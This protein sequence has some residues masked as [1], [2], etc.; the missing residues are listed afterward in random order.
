MN[1]GTKVLALALAA[2]LAMGPLL[3]PQAG[4]QS[5]PTTTLKTFKDGHI[6]EVMNF[7]KAG[8][9]STGVE[10]D[11]NSVVFNASMVASS[12]AW[13]P[14]GFDYP[15]DPY[16]DIGGDG[17]KDWA[18]SGLGYGRWGF[19]DVFN[20]NSSSQDFTFGANETRDFRFKIPKGAN[21]LGG[22]FT[23]SGLPDPSWGPQFTVSTTKNVVPHEGNSTQAVFN[24]KLYVAWESLDPTVTGGTNRDIIYRSFDGKKWGPIKELTM[25]GDYMEDENPFLI[26][27][28]NRLYC[29]WSAAQNEKF[30]SNDDLLMRYSADGTNWSTLFKVSP[31]I[32]GG[33]S[34]IPAAV[35][36]Q[37]QLYI[38]WRTTDPNIAHSTSS[39]DTD[40]VYRV[41]DGNSFISNDEITKGDNGATDWGFGIAVY[42]NRLYIFWEMA[43]GGWMN[44][45]SAY[46]IM[47][48]SYD[49]SSW[50]G[51]KELFSD[52]EELMDQAPKAYVWF[53][54]VKKMDM[55]YVIWGR[56]KV[57]N[58]MGTG[59]LD[60]WVKSYDGSKW[61]DKLKL[62]TN[63][64]MNL[65]QGLTTYNGRLYA[66]WIQEQQGVY[67]E[68]NGDRDVYW[69]YGE[70]FVR[71][72]DGTAWGNT[73][74]LTPGG[75][76]NLGMDPSMCVFGDKLYAAWAVK[77]HPNYYSEDWDI[78][79]RVL[80]FEDV[81]L[82]MDIGNDGVNDWS[83]ELTSQNIMIPINATPVMKA[84]MGGSITDAYKNR[85]TEVTIGLKARN[86]AKIA[87]HD[88]KLEYDYRVPFDFK[89]QLNKLLQ[90]TRA[91]SGG[92]GTNAT[93]GLPMVVGTGSEGVVVLENLTIEYLINHAPF[94]VKEIPIIDMNEDIDLPDALDLEDYF[95]DDLDD[96]HLHFS[97]P[98][99]D[100]P[101]HLMPILNGSKLGFVTP[102][103]DWN[104][105]WNVTVVA[106]DNFGL[107]S[108][109]VKIKVHVWPVNDPPLLDFIPNQ[110]LKVS[111]K[112]TYKCR[113]YDPDFGEKLTFHTNGKNPHIDADSGELT[114]NPSKRG[115][116]H[117]N[118]SVDDGQGLWDSQN[119][120]YT[121]MGES[122]SGGSS[123]CFSLIAFLVLALV[124][125]LVAWKFKHEATFSP[126]APERLKIGD[127]DEEEDTPGADAKAAG[128]A[129]GPRKAKRPK[130]SLVIPGMDVSYD[131]YTADKDEPV[132]EATVVEV[133]AAEAL[134]VKA[135]D[136]KAAVKEDDWDNV[137]DELRKRRDKRKAELKAKA[138]GKKAQ[139]DVK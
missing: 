68:D 45:N 11:Q 97:M 135:A 107:Y 54:P 14:D 57:D 56:G 26:V 72:F 62:T 102:T 25:G 2:L 37:D 116:Y 18:Y 66:Y 77:N 9:Q 87:V 132:E 83:G 22:S 86:P 59:F 92:S 78:V 55:L 13:T 117:F 51:R 139:G 90:D 89:V 8:K 67:L 126:V 109:P 138:D 39:T 17:T 29:I 58:E 43:N 120:T 6:S 127:D 23:A 119:V 103:E 123:N 19:Q 79:M 108:L 121:V 5:Y 3:A 81:L 53:D 130:P 98:S 84:M 65:Q 75:Q 35:V 131:G 1:H 20:D 48:K 34:D 12:K 99:M 63:G 101:N 41:W 71:D 27:Y 110:T 50:T 105:W 80:G 4:A 85:I 46:D 128:K 100:D 93:V 104:G 111:E 15:R 64:A 69:Y 49:G 129:K 134:V 91:Q 124:I 16:I 88:L 30:Y 10:L 7:I 122:T 133:P 32:T 44:L 76:V 136:A 36:F 47:Y 21:V 74:Q 38:F 24:G 61:S 95:S 28:D 113:A 73:V 106:Y 82:D 52:T 33:M 94:Q 96:G 137:A 42:N 31:A 115:E 112:F 114:F 40:I 118:V 60:I 125:I 70:L